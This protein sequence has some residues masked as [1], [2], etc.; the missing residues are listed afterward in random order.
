R[1]MSEQGVDI[2]SHSLT[3]PLLT[4]PGKPMNKKDYEAWIDNELVESKRRLEE[5]LKKP[6]PSLAY[7]YGGYDE[8]IV[9]RVRAAGYHTALTCDD[10][11]VAGFTDP[12][13][14]TRRLVF[15]Q[16]SLKAYTRSFMARPLQMTDL[17]PRD[18]ER[19]K[20]LPSRIQARIANLQMIQPGTVQIL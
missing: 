20:A 9:Q 15:R 10:G 18:G 11:D 4:H 12:L 2:E 14:L 3:H 8:R 16:T 13:R 6:V 17:P 5:K 19:L 7:P 1:E